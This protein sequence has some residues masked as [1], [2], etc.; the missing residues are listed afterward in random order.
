LTGRENIFLN[1]AILGMTKREIKN[2]F[3][4]IVA[5]AEIG[6]FIDTP[7]KRYSSGMHVRL[8][9]AVAAH[10]EPEILLVDEVL[11]VGDVAFQ[12]KCLG[13]MGDVA[14]EGRTVLFVS[15]NLGAVGQLCKTGLVLEQG[16]ISYRGE[17][18]VAINRYLA[19][20]LDHSGAI[21]SFTPDENKPL[22]I[23]EVSV[24]G[25]DGKVHNRFDINDEICLM[26]SYIVRK[27]EPFLTLAMTM[28]RNG[29]ELLSSFDVDAQPK[30]IQERQRGVFVAKIH[31][32]RRLLKS[33]IYSITFAT[34]YL[35]AKVIEILRDAITFQVQELSE[36]TMFKS[37][38]EERA[39][40]IISDL[41]WEDIV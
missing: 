23:L 9:F 39:G 11:A 18:A 32:P 31:L 28:S 16:K 17:V 41:T 14:K 15:H 24:R 2:K 27:P 21:C 35:K 5:F 38:A 20:T 33:G 1:G 13:K 26:V 34:G 30:R 8:A 40:M 4:E 10:L 36:V 19:D 22:Q 29:A 12:R 6:K 37:Y 25:N 3:D 7:V